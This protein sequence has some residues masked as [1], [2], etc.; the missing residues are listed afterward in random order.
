MGWRRKTNAATRRSNGS[1]RLR[2]SRDPAVCF[3]SEVE[4]PGGGAR[5]CELFALALSYSHCTFLGSLSSR[6]EE[7]AGVVAVFLCMRI[8][9]VCVLSSRPVFPWMNGGVLLSWFPIVRS[10]FSEVVSSFSAKRQTWRLKNMN[11]I[12]FSLSVTFSV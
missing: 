12:Y 6:A 7:G 8:T 1:A 11:H 9:M 4:T 3:A 5:G 2:L 10:L